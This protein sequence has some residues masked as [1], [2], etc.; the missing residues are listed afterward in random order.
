MDIFSIKH[1][2]KSKASIFIL[3]LQIKFIANHKCS[4]HHIDETSRKEMCMEVIVKLSPT[5][6]LSSMILNWL[7]KF[8]LSQLMKAR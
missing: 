6:K 3:I 7:K 2:S 5:K 8:C 1:K 4:S